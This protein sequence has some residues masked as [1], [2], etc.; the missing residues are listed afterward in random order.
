MVHLLAVLIEESRLNEPWRL[1]DLKGLTPGSGGE[2]TDCSRERGKGFLYQDNGENFSVTG[3][4]GV[5]SL[6]DD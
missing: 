5:Q 3:H 2:L 1:R 4:S 6:K